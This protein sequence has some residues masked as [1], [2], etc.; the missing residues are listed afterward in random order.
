MVAELTLAYLELELV[1]FERT[2]LLSGCSFQER[3]MFCPMIV[4]V[5]SGWSGALGVDELG[6]FVFQLRP[7]ALCTDRGFT[8]RTRTNS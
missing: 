2:P 8:T 4:A 6:Y 5:S 7:C 3:T 1:A